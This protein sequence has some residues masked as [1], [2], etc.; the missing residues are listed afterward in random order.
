[1]FFLYWSLLLSFS[2]PILAF[3]LLTNFFLV[4]DVTELSIKPQLG[5]MYLFLIEKRDRITVYSLLYSE[6]ITGFFIR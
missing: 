6:I 1:M 4:I 2:L 5:F 3:L